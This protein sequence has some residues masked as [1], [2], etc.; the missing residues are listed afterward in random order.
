M[1]NKIG[2][3]KYRSYIHSGVFIPYAVIFFFAIPYLITVSVF[4]KWVSWIIIAIGLIAFFYSFKWINKEMFDIYFKENEIEIK[5]VFG[6]NSQIIDYKDIVKY[7]FINTSKN[8][9]NSFKTSNQ[10]FV[11]NRVVSNNKFIEFYKFLKSKNENIKIEI[12]PLSS[13]LEYLR[14]QEFDLK[15]REFLKETL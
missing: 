9:R 10:Y 13:D 5:Y 12:F 14:Q 15:Y 2:N 7:S 1:E 6:D 11:F 8:T 4:E 3:I